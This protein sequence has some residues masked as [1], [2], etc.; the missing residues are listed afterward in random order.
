[1]YLDVKA[2]PPD[3]V[4]VLFKVCNKCH[5]QNFEFSFYGHTNSRD[6]RNCRS[7]AG[8]AGIVEN[9]VILDMYGTDRQTVKDKSPAYKLHR[10][11]QQS[12]S[13]HAIHAMKESSFMWHSD[14]KV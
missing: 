5:F 3:Y 7:I 1:M 13:K 9:F 10:W 2:G 4:S 11:A 8:I 12:T 14:S 6:T